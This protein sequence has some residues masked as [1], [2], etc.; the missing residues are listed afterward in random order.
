MLVIFNVSGPVRP[1]VAPSTTL[2]HPLCIAA[3]AL[4][5]GEFLARE[6]PR[7]ISGL[8]SEPVPLTDFASYESFFYGDVSTRKKRVG[9]EDEG[10]TTNWHAVVSFSVH[11]T[12]RAD[13]FV[14]RLELAVSLEP[15]L[16]VK[17]SVID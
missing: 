3:G 13:D 6:I 1:C 11:E 8:L 12:Q 4:R 15:S 5:L 9:R 2:R 10:R 17:M 16:C 14:V 7:E